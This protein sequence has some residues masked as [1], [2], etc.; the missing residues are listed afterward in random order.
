MAIRLAKFRSSRVLKYFR[1]RWREIGGIA[2]GLTLAAE[3]EGLLRLVFLAL[4]ATMVIGLLR[5]SW[6]NRRGGVPRSP[7]PGRGP[8]DR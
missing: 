3:R 8:A 7:L 6:A 2:L 1:T 5:D 4:S